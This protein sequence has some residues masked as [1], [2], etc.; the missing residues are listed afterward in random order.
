MEVE[1]IKRPRKTVKLYGRS[2]STQQMGVVS[3]GIHARIS[4]DDRLLGDAGGHPGYY[5][6][7]RAYI[8]LKGK[9]ERL[10]GDYDRETSKNSSLSDE[11]CAERDSLK[12]GRSGA[13]SGSGGPLVRRRQTG[14]WKPLT[15]RNK[16]Q[17]DRGEV[18]GKNESKCTLIKIRPAHLERWP[19]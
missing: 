12:G 1:A 4:K 13:M 16:P 18:Q 5:S 14:Y 15:G 8:E 17:R 11:V 3:R 10:L 9:Y 6:G 2:S 7:Y 19:Y